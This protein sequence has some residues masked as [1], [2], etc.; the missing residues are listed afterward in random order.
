MATNLKNAPPDTYSIAIERA[1]IYDFDGFSPGRLAP[2]DCTSLL[3]VA[4]IAIPG[5]GVLRVQRLLDAGTHYAPDRSG[6]GG[7]SLRGRFSHTMGKARYKPYQ[8]LRLRR[9]KPSLL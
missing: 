3:L 7:H 6:F 1:S 4:E 9:E 5:P 8:K 2:G